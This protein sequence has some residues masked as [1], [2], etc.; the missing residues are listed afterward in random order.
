[1]AALL[2]L[3]PA[4]WNGYVLFYFDSV[5]Y[6]RMSYTWEMPVWRTMPYTLV[7]A[8]GRIA[9]TMWAVPVAQ[10]LVMAWVLYEFLR[11]FTRLSPSV[12]LVPLTGLLVLS[13]GL[14]WFASQVMADMFTGVVVLGI[15]ILAFGSDRLGRG[16]ALVLAALVAVGGALHTSHLAVGGGLVLCLM[17]LRLAV[18]RRWP[19][20]NP[21]IMPAALAMAAAVGLVMVVHWTTVGRPFISQ[22]NS[23]LLLARLVQDGIAKRYLDDVCPKYSRKLRG[24][25]AYRD[26]LP[27]TANDFLWGR[28]PFHKLG[29]WR[30]MEPVAEDI[31]EESLDRYPLL[32]LEAAL[33]L[34]GEQLAMV[35]TGDG[36]IDMRWHIEQALALYYPHELDA[37]LAARQQSGQSIDG[38]NRLHVPV[39]F[40]ATLLTLALTLHWGRRRDARTFGLAFVVVMAL[41]GNAFVCGALSNPN[42]RYQSRIA[43]LTVLV[44][45]TAVARRFERREM[46]GQTAPEAI[47]A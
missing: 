29:G 1:M 7:A 6:V 22:P 32:H 19:E 42:H 3:L 47:S 14:P 18:R 23:V 9:G 30:K 27:L 21:R 26:G 41:L 17:V 38:I 45:A 33:K 46:A 37:F 10:S 8:L 43:W 35:E 24:L 36:L 11:A 31:L 2:L 12:A 4:L 40:V 44:V 15:G 25:C 13:T 39:L 34:W 28:S 20:A 5:D 16:R